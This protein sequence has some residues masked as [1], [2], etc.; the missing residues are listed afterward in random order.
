V[1]HHNPRATAYSDNLLHTGYT[2]VTREFPGKR[3]RKTKAST[4]NPNILW[5]IRVK[6]RGF[7][8][9]YWGLIK[10]LAWE[11]SNTCFQAGM[12]LRA[13]TRGASGGRTTIR[14]FHFSSGVRQDGP[15]RV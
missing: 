1:P 10:I 14:M 5:S 11:F 15:P 6:L 2:Q 12:L 7:P 8:V 9:V 4:V 3:G 13:A